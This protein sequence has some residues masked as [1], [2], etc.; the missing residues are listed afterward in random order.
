[1]D[2]STESLA[3]SRH[4][5]TK[6]V[7]TPTWAAE[8]TLRER[9][10]VE[11]Y[12]IDLN[13]RQAAIRAQLGKTIKSATEIASRMRKKATVAAAIGALMAERSGATATAVLSELGAVAFSRISNYL[14]I[15]KGRLV[16]AVSNLNDLSDEA[17]AAIA[18]LKERVNDDGTVSIEVELHSKIDALDKLA[19]VLSLY[20]ER[21]E[22]AHTHEHTFDVDPLDAIN[23]RLNALARAQRAPLVPEI[24]SPVR[25]SLPPVKDA[26]LII[27]HE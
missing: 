17:G 12:I 27:D 19:K 23:E 16:L 22:V 13:G 18:K 21:A 1:L 8:L 2:V 10:F 20:R 9:R 7:N 5:P 25:R 4:H 11:E 6:T 24:D 15:D 26:P 14:K 3:L